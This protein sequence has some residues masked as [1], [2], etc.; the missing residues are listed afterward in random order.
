MLSSAVL[1]SEKGSSDSAYNLKLLAELD[2]L[3]TQRRISSVYHG[4]V[5]VPP[6]FP[7]TAPVSSDGCSPSQ[8]SDSMWQEFIETNFDFD[9]VPFV[10]FFDFPKELDQQQSS[11]SPDTGSQTSESGPKLSRDIEAA[12]E[13]LPS[14]NCCRD[15]HIRCDRELPLCGVCRRSRR[16]CTYYDPIL[17]QDVPRRHIHHLM[18]K[19]KGVT[20]QSLISRIGSVPKAGLKPKSGVNIFIPALEPRKSCMSTTSGT[21]RNI[22]PSSANWNHSFFGIS[23]HLSCISPVLSPLARLTPMSL[24]YEP[25]AIPSVNINTLTNQVPHCA[26]STVLHLFATFSRSAHIWYPVMDDASLNNLLSSSAIDRLG[27]ALDHAHELIFLILAIG[28]QLT[29]RAEHCVS[30]TSI[31]YFERATAHLDTTC[32]HSSTS[33]NLYL[34][35]RTLLIC[36]YLLLTPSAGDIWRNLG[37]AVRLYFDLSHRPAE[38]SDPRDTSQLCMLSRTL[39]C[40]ECQVSVAFGRPTLLVIGDKLRDEMMQRQL[41]TTNERISIY[42][43]RISFLKMQIHSLVLSEASS[44]RDSATLKSHLVEL[45]HGLR[46]WHQSW[47]QELLSSP[48]DDSQDW[49]KAIQYLQAWGDLNY[50]AGVLLLSK[51]ST[52][53]TDVTDT[54]SAC[55]LIVSSSNLLVRHQQHSLCSVLDTETQRRTPVFPIDWTTSHLIFSAGVRL[56]ASRNQGKYTIPTWERA[57]RSCLSSVALLESDPANL[58]M[59][60][61][62]LLEGLCN[63]DEDSLA[64]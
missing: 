16:E 8:F 39:Y 24:S 9:D 6:S 19:I 55:C 36:I 29:K 25:D 14:C 17:L 27:S 62:E 59:G 41:G 2:F 47:N 31:A 22:E 5:E 64:A 32:E 48:A 49:G 7:A 28:S 23:S 30:F 51:C 1:S 57:M 53:A 40:L 58:S 3:V 42:F 26:S 11:V 61:S 37:F 50:N 34:L 45:W 46:D 21:A 60:Y 54:M 52:E 13:S 10:N 38:T 63:Y 18:E 12:I 35:Q 56:V 15:Q 20:Q 4:N 43:Y 33:S 44:Q